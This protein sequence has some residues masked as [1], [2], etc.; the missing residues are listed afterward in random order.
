MV[1][2]LCFLSLVKTRRV[3]KVVNIKKI[4]PLCAK[5]VYDG[6][7]TLAY[8][9]AVRLPDVRVEQLADLSRLYGVHQREGVI[10]LAY[11]GPVWEGR[12]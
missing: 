5:V 11:V 1:E 2:T 6:N 9:S 4:V 3:P 7:V 12:L 10:Q 8:A